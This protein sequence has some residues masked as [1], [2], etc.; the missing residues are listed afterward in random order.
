MKYLLT[1]GILSLTFLNEISYSQPTAT[2]Q[3][4]GGYSMPLGDYK[5]TFGETID[6]FTGGGNPDS[7]TYFMHAGYNYGIFIKVPIKKKS[8]FSIKGGISFNS[9]GQ[10]KEYPTSTTTSVTVTLKQ[11][12]LGIT[13]GSEYDFGYRKNKIRPFIGAE[14]AGNLFAGSFVEDYVDSTE[15][16]NLK[17]AFRLGV[18]VAAG[19]DF[20]VHNNIGLLIGAKFAFANLIGKS[21]AEDERFKYNL[22]DDKHTVNNVTYPSKNITYLQFYGGMSFYFGR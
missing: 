2:V 7:N 15:T 11:S 10:S 22:N 16:F 6:K 13:L 5:G 14:L 20:I 8:S 18:N 1:I 12:V 4:I 21:Y 17:S 9:F 19:V 3:F